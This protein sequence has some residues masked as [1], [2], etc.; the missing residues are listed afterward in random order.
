MG[1]TT[2]GFRYPEVTDRVAD[3]ATAIKNLALDVD[4]GLPKHLATGT[5]NATATTTATAAGTYYAITAT[6]VVIPA[7]LASG[8]RI[9]VIAHGRIASG[10]AA[11]NAVLGLYRGTTSLNGLGV[12]RLESASTGYRFTEYFSEAA[13]AAGTYDYRLTVYS[14]GGASLTLAGLQLDVYLV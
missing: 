14:G 11:V 1:T 7:G 13:P 6:G 4:G 9:M 8:R 10:T 5:A 2:R 12:Y 3:G